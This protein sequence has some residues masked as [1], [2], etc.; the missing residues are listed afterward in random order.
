M[1]FAHSV[2]PCQRCP[3]QPA[4]QLYV[5]LPCADAIQP[6]QSN[7]TDPVSF[8]HCRTQFSYPCH[9]L[10]HYVEPM[11]SSAVRVV[12]LSASAAPVHQHCCTHALVACCLA[13]KLIFQ[14]VEHVALV[15]PSG[16]EQLSLGFSALV[17][18]PALGKSRLRKGSGSAV[19][20]SAAASA[21][22]AT[23]G[24]VGHLWSGQRR[25]G[26]VAPQATHG[27]F[28]PN[29]PLELTFYGVP[30]C[31]GGNALRAF[32]ATMPTLPAVARSSA[33]R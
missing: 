28:Q 3:P 16:Q 2:P 26:R 31:P 27:Q 33:L 18:Q 24:N 30:P 5:R 13:M 19:A 32:C 14:R 25:R 20:R 22:A 6:L 12:A 11:C 29:P 17:L 23:Q 15:L 9:P 21:R 4:A 7:A 8:A 10:P 1:R